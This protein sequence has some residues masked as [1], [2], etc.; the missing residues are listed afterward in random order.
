[1]VMDSSRNSPNANLFHAFQIRCD[2]Q[3]NLDVSRQARVRRD[4]L[5]RAKPE[6]IAAGSW[7][8]GEMLRVPRR[9]RAEPTALHQP[10]GSELREF[11]FQKG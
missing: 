2:R 3:H 4:W 1:M 8:F 5:D 11:A 6:L 9:L 7:E 10:L